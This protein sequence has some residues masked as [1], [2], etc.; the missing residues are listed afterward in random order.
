MKRSSDY[1]NQHENIKKPRFG[2]SYNSYALAN[3]GMRSELGQATASGDLYSHQF[4]PVGPSAMM[5]AAN[6]S[7][8]Q[9]AAGFH[10]AQSGFAGMGGYHQGASQY[11]AGMSQYN[12]GVSNMVPQFSGAFSSAQFPSAYPQAAAAAALSSVTNS[13]GRTVY[14]GNIP[15]DVPADEILNQVKVGPIES[16]RILPEKNCAFISF[17]DGTAAAAFYHDASTRKLMI[18]GQELKV[19]WGKPSPVPPNVQVAV[20]TQ[21]ASRNVYLGNLDD[22]ITEQVLR[23]DLG[24]FGTIETVKIVREKNIGFVHF[25]TIT[26]AIKA[27]QTLPQESKYANKKVNYGKDRCAV[28]PTS[29]N[30]TT[31]QFTFTPSGTIGFQTFGNAGA[32]G[33][34]AFD[35]YQVVAAAASTHLENGSELRSP[36]SP[37]FSSASSAAGSTTSGSQVGNR[38]IYLGNIHQDTTCEEICNVIRGGILHQ[39]RY[40]ADKH[41]AFV[42]FVDPTAANNFMFLAQHQGVVIKNR[43]LK[44][45]WGKNSGPLPGNIQLAVNTQNASRNVYVGSLDDSITEEKLRRD[46]SEFGEIELVNILKEKSCGF[47]NFTS[48]VYAIKAIEGIKAK[49]EYRKFRINY[50]KDRCGNAP[51]GL[52]SSGSTGS[53]S[54]TSKGRNTG[55][56]DARILHQGDT[57][58]SEIE[59]V[60]ATDDVNEIDDDFANLE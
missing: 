45:G 54:K 1:G 3:S 15:T 8:T 47:V 22:S 17:M 43:R 59:N 30:G 38:T 31:S 24:K 44:V 4:P 28:R 49:E 5:M 51:R 6:H 55:E 57:E 18:H 52:T 25:L 46:F 39:I 35:P 21:N 12:P 41:I 36:T 58:E 10:P 34:A 29:G 20:S 42:T 48:I 13:T 19:G 40:M 37:L 32:M 7:Y 50:G 33:F 56:S 27:V 9:S 53:A 60:E 26:S 2:Q 16:V 11:A 23:D 14:L